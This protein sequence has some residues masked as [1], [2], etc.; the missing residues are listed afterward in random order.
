MSTQNRFK[1]I[2]KGTTFNGRDIKI[3]NGTG[4]SKTP[5]DLTGVLIEMKFRSIVSPNNGTVVFQ[6][7]T[8]DNSITITGLGVA[9]MMP[10]LKFNVP[11]ADY[12]AD[13]IL[14]LP[15][16]TVKPYGELYWKVN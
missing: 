12:V 14:T 4:V 7:T 13:L 11:V 1:T 15:N 3:Y 5:M 2:K 10:R 8:A 16:G 6:F 9:R